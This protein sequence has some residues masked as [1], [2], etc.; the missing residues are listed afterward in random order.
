[1]GFCGA[2]KIKV[3]GLILSSVLNKNGEIEMQN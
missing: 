2:I 1:M 3:S